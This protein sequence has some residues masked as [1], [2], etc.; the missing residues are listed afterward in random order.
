MA[1]IYR[2]VHIKTGRCYVG[3]T[4]LKP[5]ARWGRHKHG[6]EKGKHHARHL[7]HAW[8]KYGPNA[9][10]FEVIEE[11]AETDKLAREQHWIDTLNPIF[12]VARVAGSILGY[13]FTDEQIA[14][15]I[16]H[17]VS[18][19]TRA[20]IAAKAM[21]NQ[22]TKGLVW[23]DKARS[24]M[25][26]ATKNKPRSEAQRQSTI[27]SLKLA[28]EKSAANKPGWIP[29]HRIGVKDSA[30]TIEKRRASRLAFEAARKEEAKRD[31]NAGTEEGGL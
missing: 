2:I 16:G 25:S 28:R 19:E 14:K 1:W 5:S 12:N 23:D 4:S 17:E 24:N 15:R 31:A 8:L 13:K 29:T 22:R 27:N 9:F 10:K 30:E 3:H 6:L 20:K 7:Q 18:A 26:K 21:G 11:C